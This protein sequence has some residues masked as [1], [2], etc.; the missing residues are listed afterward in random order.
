MVSSYLDD[1]ASTQKAFRDGWFYPGDRARL[2]SRGELRIIGRADNT[3]NVN[4]QKLPAENIEAAVRRL[5]GVA[6]V[7]VTTAP[8][9]FG[10]LTMVLLIVKGAGYSEK[11]VKELVETEFRF[12]NFRIQ[13]VRKIPRNDLGKT[14]R[15]RAGSAGRS[16]STAVIEETPTSH[17]WTVGFR[18]FLLLDAAAQI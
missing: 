15:H 2:G 8:I 5:P 13:I 10:S 3:I 4:G 18:D 6:D 12:R 9:T 11:R 16:E 7:A 1:E 17:A 14:E